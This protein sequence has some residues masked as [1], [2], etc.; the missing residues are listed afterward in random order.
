MNETSAGPAPASNRRR[1]TIIT[2]A[3][4]GTVGIAAGAVLGVGAASGAPPLTGPGPSAYLQPANNGYGGDG[5]GADHGR[6]GGGSAATAT[7]ATGAQQVGVVDID[8]ILGYQNAEAAGT[9]M[10]L[11]SDG[12]VLTNNHV[13]D[14]ATSITV[15]VVSSGD[16]YTATVVGT[17]P[18]A[19]VAVLHLAGASGL[20]TAELSTS[21]ATVGE[22]VTAVGNA[23]GAGTLSAAGGTVTA[24]DQ[25][26]TATDSTGSDAEQLSGLIETDAG[27]QPGD[28][29]GPLY[30]SAGA[31]V[32]MDT[33]ASS[34]GAVQAYA[35]PISAAEGIATQIEQGVSSATIHQGYPAFLGVSSTDGQG[36]VTVLAVVPNGPA[37]SAGIT[38]GDVITV[39]GGQAVTSA[40]ELSAALAGDSPGQQVTV[41]WADAIGGVH[42]ATVT[43][44]TGPAL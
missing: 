15:T 13:V 37:A 2:V 32:G 1:T 33:A 4:L 35:I 30:D 25:S 8:S 11:T 12:N 31:I 20:A 19:D 16:T 41:T 14:G 17:D 34:G 44:G 3:A 26:I 5:A 42:S 38:A 21:P 36:S 23:G 43:L 6:Y 7:T 40:S 10:V 24:L 29:G 9:G 22:A 28:S 18:Y 39:V 27:V